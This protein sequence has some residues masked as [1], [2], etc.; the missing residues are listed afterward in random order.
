MLLV[1]GRVSVPKPLSQIQRS[2]RWLLQGLSPRP[3]FGGFGFSN[4]SRRNSFPNQDRYEHT[5]DLGNLLIG[6]C[7]YDYYDEET[8]GAYY[9]LLDG[10]DTTSESGGCLIRRDV[11]GTIAGGW[12][13]EPF[14]KEST[15]GGRAGWALAMGTSTG[16][17]VRVN[18]EGR[19]LRVSAGR[20]TY[21]DPKLVTSEHCYEQ[22]QNPTAA[23]SGFAYLKLLSDAELAVA[24]GDGGC[25]QQLPATYQTY[26]R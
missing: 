1:S 5:G 7:P 15:L 2:T 11:P 8:R 18:A 23:P 22:R 16:G 24:F 4:S 10:L 26:H 13:R 21:V 19:S 6:D 20:P 12:F 14:V 17:E 9:A 3:S 25:P